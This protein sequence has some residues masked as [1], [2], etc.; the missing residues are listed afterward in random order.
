MLRQTRTRTVL[1][2]LLVVIAG[3]FGGCSPVIPAPK[4]LPDLHLPGV[5]Q[6]PGVTNLHR[7]IRRGNIVGLTTA[8]SLVPGDA[9][10]AIIGVDD[11]LFTIG[12]DGSTPRAIPTTCPMN[13]GVTLRTTADRRWLFCQGQSLTALPLPGA[14]TPAL[15]HI[16]AL[17]T[18]TGASVQE[19]DT[20]WTVAPD[21][22][23]VAVLMS[24]RSQCALAL[25]AVASS[26]DAVPLVGVLLLPLSVSI[27][28]LG[29][30]HLASPVWSPNGPTGPW[31]AFAHCEGTCSEWGF[32]PQSYL[33]RLSAR[34]SPTILTVDQESL[35]EIAGASA[36]FSLTWTLAPEGL[37]LNYLH[38]F[39][40]WQTS[41]TTNTPHL[42]LAL[43]QGVA[44]GLSALAA[45]PDT[46]GLVFA[47]S[48]WQD[49]CP[50]CQGGET[51]SHLY[52]FTPT[53]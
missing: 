22:R 34:Q 38:S 8:L 5:T 44:G 49:S 42:L 32:P 7:G 50:E 4:P 52:Y 25:Y 53:A 12:F 30:C 46:Q 15:E 16:L 27:P 23:Y 1:L 47:H 11:E 31:L 21:G 43:P 37:R 33:S 41:L 51:P 39:G 13:R 2:L 20:R 19:L 48:L 18:D 14:N 10:R 29:N 36:G 40:I 35:Q 6:I 26:R 17:Q 24:A 45:T 28:R 3:M 9:P